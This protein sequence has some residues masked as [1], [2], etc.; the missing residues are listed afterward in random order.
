[1]LNS[2]LAYKTIP[3]FLAAAL[4]ALVYVA[5]PIVV[6]FLVVAGFKFIAAPG[7]SSKLEEAKRNL[8]YVII[9][10]LFILGAQLV[11]TLISNTVKQLQTGSSTAIETPIMR[12]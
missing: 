8:L 3:E 11:S 4:Q 1:M 10:A 9:G 5:I 2:P 12:A 7:N 6:L